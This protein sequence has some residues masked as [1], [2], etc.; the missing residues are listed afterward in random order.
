MA[1]VD[2][3]TARRYLVGF[4]AIEDDDELA[5]W[6]LV[7]ES[8]LH[9]WLRFPRSDAGT[10]A[11]DAATYTLYYD[12]PARDD[13]RRLDVG[14][15]PLVSVTSI[16]DDPEWDWDNETVSSGNYSADLLRG[17]I[18]LTPTSTHAW[19]HARRA[20]RAI[21]SAGFT[22]TDYDVVGAVALQARHLWEARNVP[23]MPNA[24][25]IEVDTSTAIPPMVRQMLGVHRL[26]GR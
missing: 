18:H 14:V 1:L 25:D 12:A 16:A 23:G 19:S 8:V 15:W 26:W 6:L 20:I 13:I 10:R 4:D 24:A 5:D 3:E 2:A 21:V 9:A 7:A 22:A 11:L 17:E